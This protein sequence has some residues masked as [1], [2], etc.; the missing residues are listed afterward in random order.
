MK[1]IILVLLL[2]LPH[3]LICQNNTDWE[4]LDNRLE[5]TITETAKKLGDDE[6]A[7]ASRYNEFGSNTLGW[8]WYDV[9]V[10]DEEWIYT[11]WIS[12]AVF[13][14]FSAAN[15]WWEDENLNSEY[16][17]S[18]D[19]IAFWS[20]RQEYPFHNYTCVI[21]V[22]GFEETAVEGSIY[23]KSGEFIL[24][25][26]PITKKTKDELE[27]VLK[28]DLE[29]LH[30]QSGNC[31][32][33]SDVTEVAYFT[34]SFSSTYTHYVCASGS[35]TASA[36]NSN[37][38]FVEIFEQVEVSLIKDGNTLHAWKET[39]ISGGIPIRFNSSVYADAVKLRL[40][41]NDAVS[42][43]VEFNLRQAW[44]IYLVDP[45]S[46]ISFEEE[47]ELTGKL[48][49]FMPGDAE[50]IAILFSE[51]SELGYFS[52]DYKEIGTATTF[53]NTY[54][55]P[56]KEDAEGHTGV[57]LYIRINLCGGRTTNY[58]KFIHFSD[59][60]SNNQGFNN[61]TS[62]GNASPGQGIS[63]VLDPEEPST[64][65]QFGSF[66]GDLDIDNHTLD[67]SLL[68]H[69]VYVQ[70]IDLDPT[71]QISTE[72][73]KKLT[74]Y[75][76]FQIKGNK[77]IP[78]T[79][80]E[81]GIVALM[82]DKGSVTIGD[83]TVTRG[84]GGHI[85]Q[86]SINSEGEVEDLIVSENLNNDDIAQ[87]EAGDIVADSEGNTIVTGSFKDNIAFSG[88][89]IPRPGALKSSWSSDGDNDPNS[90]D[91]FL[92]KHD[93]NG[94]LLW[95]KAI[96]SNHEPTYMPYVTAR[97]LAT[98]QDGNL[99]LGGEY[100][101][102]VHI[103]GTDLPGKDAFVTKIDS[104]GNVQW[105]S[106]I[107][108]PLPSM[109]LITEIEV[110]ADQGIYVCG[111]AATQSTFGGMVW[112]DWD[113]EY[114]LASSFVT[115]YNLDGV[116][117]WVRFVDSDKYILQACNDLAVDDE[118]NVY[119]TGMFQEGPI[120]IDTIELASAYGAHLNRMVYAASFT[121]EGEVRWAHMAGDDENPEIWDQDEGMSIDVS[122]EGDC[123]I[124]GTFVGDMAIGNDTLKS[125]G[126]TD[127]FIVRIPNSILADVSSPLIQN[128]S[129]GLSNLRIY[130]Q[131][132]SND[133]TCSFD[134][135]SAT[136]V[137]VSLM[138]LMGRIQNTQHIEV[139]NP[140]KQSCTI[141]CAPIATGIYLIHISSSQGSL[142]QKVWIN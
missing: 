113:G 30:K 38:E 87:H 93:A 56:S 46:K 122:A 96:A 68:Y 45:P 108:G 140:G 3:L 120:R 124:T 77:I 37:N 74:N 20:Y 47:V 116:P 91:I 33:F 57:Q 66:A 60:G 127:T 121:P 125:A 49:R 85:I 54:T 98:D 128:P 10:E 43:S 94:N 86:A 42:E 1:P 97:A 109:A 139:S 44:D 17:N 13:E 136:A 25:V 53:K 51:T 110:S 18:N 71:G 7:S 27:N 29:E 133:L 70:K 132:V 81:T 67:L 69:G 118:G 61:A 107:T 2:T 34:F 12:G 8:D 88:S 6:A 62:H 78:L 11:H 21:E 50:D 134:A 58:S 28:D 130:N 83:H 22:R 103:G 48:D 40:Q 14:S 59:G 137:T 5:C 138:D 95:G 126:S 76:S 75:D 35:I 82:T 123:I 141:D 129:N 84:Q 80:Q 52:E 89:E 79:T 9:E 101:G 92:V 65:Y 23:W 4:V 64:G 135:T 105:V 106:H 111:T 131:P 142:S 32:L 15:A 73:A 36:Y 114:N 119:V 26:G 112:S 99:Y 102:G 63:I 90:F 104:D 115:K 31:N 19:T 24:K 16:D 41:Y 55:A 39:G 100:G 117:Q 72:W